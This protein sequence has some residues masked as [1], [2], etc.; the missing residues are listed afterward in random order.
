MLLS[1]VSSCLIRSSSEFP[2]TPDGGS[3]VKKLLDRVPFSPE[4][5]DRVIYS[6]QAK[7][8][9]R[10]REHRARG[11]KR[12]RDGQRSPAA[13]GEGQGGAAWGAHRRGDGGRSM[14]VLE[15]DEPLPR[16]R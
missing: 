1:R 3:T 8:C 10:R 7:F 15:K 14:A 9:A 6:P 13:P 11:S 16:I 4:K 2:R 5:P 12:R